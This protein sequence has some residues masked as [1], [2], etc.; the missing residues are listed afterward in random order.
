MLRFRTPLKTDLATIIAIENTGFSPEE[1][2]T[3]EAMAQRIERISD[4]FIVAVNEEN[5]PI[6][7]VVGPVITERYLSD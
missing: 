3:S 5:L 6:G 2:A 1:A 4:S 7:Y